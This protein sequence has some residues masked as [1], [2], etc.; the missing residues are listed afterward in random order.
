MKP[1]RWA[2]TLLDWWG[3]PNTVEEVQGDLLELYAYWVKTGGERKARWRY[4][5]SVVKLLRPFAKRKEA[6]SNP[7]FLHPAMV[8][9]Y[10]KIA[11]RN[12]VK[13]KGYSGI[14]MG[15]LAVGMAVAM[16]NGLWIYDELSFNTY[17]QNYDSI[18]QV[19]ERGIRKEGTRYSGTSLPYPL[20]TELKA[21]YQSYF[22]HIL[23]S[24]QPDDYI[25]AA[26]DTKLTKKGQFI[27]AGAPEMLSLKM[28]RGTWAGLNDPHSILLSASAAEALFGKADPLDKLVRINTKMD[29]KVTGVY[30]DLPHNTGFHDIKFL[31]PFDLWTSVNPWV[32]EQQWD[33]WFLFIYAQIQ[34]NTDFD[35]V[36]ALIKDIELNKLKGLEGQQEQIARQPQIHLLPMRDWHLHGHYNMDDTGP[37][38]FVWLIGLIGV[39]VL[40]LACINF[41]NLSTARS[42]KRAKEVGIRKAVGSLRGQLIGQFFSESFLVVLLAFVWALVLVTLSLSWFNDVAAKQLSVPWTNLYFWLASVGF[43]LLTGFVAGS[44]PALYLSSFQP[45][46]VLKGVIRVGR[47]ATIPRQV[48]VVL[49]F[50]VSVTLIIGTSMVYRQIQ[51][52]KN[53]PVGYSRDGLLMIQKKTAEFS[54]KY[55]LFRTELKNTG[56]VSEVAESRSSVTNITMW[57]G[58]FSRK[59]NEIPCPNG[60]GTLSVTPEYGKTVGWEF[61]AGRDFERGRT[62]DSSGLVINESF[63]KMIGLKNPVGE[64]LV[65]ATNWRKAET[66]TVLGVVK[67]MVAMSPYEKTVPTVFLMENY[68]DWINIRI[69]PNVSTAVALPK[70]EAVFRKLVPNAPFDYKFADQEYALKFAA[71][72]RIGKLAGFFAG[73]AIFISCLG[74]FG[75]A[76][77]TAEQRTKEIGVR[78][79]LGAS[80]FNLWRLLSKDFVKLVVIAFGIATPIAWYSLATWLQNF[81]YRTEISWWIFAVSGAGALAITLLTVSFQSIKAALMNPVKSLRSE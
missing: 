24:Q 77:F 78:K 56:V 32:K 4:G 8:R 35:R 6:Y 11:F 50:T 72:E 67:D 25:L 12:L 31:A 74:L 23:I 7:F 5:L 3:D 29:A 14:N 13:H 75:L 27:E 54:G 68:H 59:G 1:P 81:Q 47:F 38:Q 19:T 17:H 48:L 70:I 57:N 15:G 53:R 36:S 43:T 46:K 66:Y 40:L 61:R 45:V 64:T 42:E 33:N 30:E 69:H 28:L 26:G 21:N 49:Q 63:A 80:V 58:G 41:M 60:C 79:V 76:S 16:L 2:S 62:T 39:F 52:A 51:Y 34:P 22:K 9:N 73:L 44:Y 20:A 37:V 10:L 18:A 65:W 71:E 55:E